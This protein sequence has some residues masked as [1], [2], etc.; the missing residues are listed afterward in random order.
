MEDYSKCYDVYRA[1]LKN[2]S[3]DFHAERE[4]N[5]S[6]V[7][8][9]LQ[10]SGSGDSVSSERETNLSAVLAALQMS[11]SGGDL[12]R[13]ERKPDVHVH[14]SIDVCVLV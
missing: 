8:A 11:G 4:T 13:G 1:Q 12:V 6:A 9:A 2:T 3:D 14:T 5:L 10:M 7:L